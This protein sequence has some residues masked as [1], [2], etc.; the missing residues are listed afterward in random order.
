MIKKEVVEEIVLSVLEVEEMLVGVSI[1][2]Q[3]DICITI[4]SET[5]VTIDRCIAVTKEIEKNFDRDQEDFS[6]EVRSAGLGDP[7]L[8]PRQYKKNEGQPVRVIKRDGE[9]IDGVLGTSNES[10]FTILTEV[11]IPSPDGRHKKRRYETVEVEL[12]YEEVKSTAY[13]FEK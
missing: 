11:M 9:R 5:G 4:D 6:L 10:S 7:F 3:N 2:P 13:R 1:S 12:S 8:L